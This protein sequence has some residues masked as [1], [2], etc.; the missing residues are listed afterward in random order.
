MKEKFCAIKNALSKKNKSRYGILLSVV[1]LIEVLMILLVSTYSWVETISSIEITNS[2]GQVDDYTFTNALVGTGEGFSGQPIDLAKYF[3]ASGN[4]HLA[5]ASSS[6]G[7]NFFFPQL[8]KTGSTKNNYRKGNINDKNTNYI[9]F[10]FKVQAV[11]TDANFYFEQVPTFKIGDTVVNDN[12]IRIALTVADA[13]GSNPVTKV[14]SNT[15][16]REQVVASISGDPLIQSSQIYAF[17]DYDN[18]DDEE[19]NILFSVRKGEENA[20]LVTLT[21]WLQDPSKSTAY[22]GKTLT[23]NNFRIVTAVK[24]TTINFVDRTSAFN[25]D[26]AKSS[27]W[28]WVGNDEAIMWI[29]TSQGAFKMQKVETSD[30]G[31]APTWTITLPTDNL[32][33]SNDDF[34]FYR[35]A[36]TVTSNPQENHYNFWKTKLSETSAAEIPTYK[37]YGNLKPGSDKEGY[38]TWGSVCEIMVTRDEEASLVL[39]TPSDPKTAT[40]ITVKT[41]NNA[42]VVPMNYNNGCWRV[43]IPNDNNSADLTISFLGNTINAI[44]RDKSESGSKFHVTSKSTGYWE[45]ASVVEVKVA[46]SCCDDKGNPIMGKVSVTGGPVGETR[47]KVTKGTPVDIIA[48]PNLIP[49]TNDYAFEGWYYDDECTKPLSSNSTESFTPV[50]K[51]KTYT[52][53]ARFQYNVRLTAITDDVKEDNAGGSV[54]INNGTAGAKASLYVKKGGS[55]TLKAVQT[56]EQAEDYT[57]MGWIDSENHVVYPADKT[58]IEITNLQEPI[59]YFAVY[60]IKTYTL[61][62]YALNGGNAQFWLDNTLKESGAHITVTVTNKQSVVYKAVPDESSGY[63]FVGWY[64][65]EACSKLKT[66]DPVFTANKNTD[67]KTY[68]AKFQLK[69]YNRTV[70]A[71]TNGTVDSAKGGTVKVI[72]D[73]A[74]SA[75]G[76]KATEKITHG[77]TAT[78]VA[79]ANDGYS[80]VGWYDAASG[81]TRISTSSTYTEKNAI[82]GDKT[83][84]A[85]FKQEFSVSLTARTDGIASST[86]GNVQAG[87]NPVGA[88]S[89]ATVLYGENITIKALVSSAKY[90]FIG[91]YDSSNT[92]QGN[93]ATKNLSNVTGNITLFADFKVK[94]FTIKAIAVSEGTEGSAGGTVEFTSPVASS[95]AT[96]TVTVNYDGSATFKATVNENDGYEFKGWF[97][98]AAMTGTPYKTDLEFELTNIVD[99]TVKT[100]YAKFDLKQYTVSAYAITTGTATSGGGTVCQVVND[101]EGTADTILN[102][103]NVKHGSQITL[104][105]KPVSGA[106]FLG[107][108]D[109]ETDGNQLAD[110]S[111]TDLVLNVEDNT[112][113][114]ARFRVSG[115]TIYF[116]PND[117][118]KATNARFAA[119]MWD[120]SVP[121]K[122]YDLTDEDGDGTYCFTSINSSTKII[123]ARMNP[124]TTSNVWDN[125]WSQTGNLDVPSGDNPCYTITGG[126]DGGN[127]STG[128][129]G[130]YKPI[131]YVS[132]NLGA[133]SIDVNGITQSDGDEFTGGSITVGSNTY[134]SA[135]VLKLDKDSSFTATAKG[136]GNYQFKGW[137]DNAACTGDPLSTGKLSVT[138]SEN[139]TYYAKFVEQSNV[140]ITFD[141]SSISSWVANDSAAIYAYDT[142]AK[143]AYIMTKD[144]SSAKY[145]C[146]VPQTVTNI[147]FYRC[148]SKYDL[149]VNTSVGGNDPG[150]AGYWNKWDAG[151]RG[152]N[153]TYST[154]SSSWS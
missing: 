122:W 146:S 59:N 6:D 23:C 89:S 91:W 117:G 49:N 33:S 41:N 51:S 11:G 126:P 104:R 149:D 42:S 24:N 57:F 61:E 74:T 106:T 65:D 22:D 28:N 129:W 14:Y 17:G 130:T 72:T 53:Y 80:F 34:Y 37:A 102:V 132:V 151:N 30:P 70:H 2:A 95:G 113:V 62:A 121:A 19:A 114:Y 44:K 119:Y 112:Q 125:K 144:S 71:V 13:D 133:V 3:R 76:A 93:E 67:P 68:Y 50:E 10:S 110:A 116:K 97:N 123:F 127:N 64:E 152:S 38:G 40:H 78:L 9:S 32:G 120:D 29:K 137:Y 36:K 16:A 150:K 31:A 147:T 45:P 105:A 12:K 26:N 143:T 21:A 100:Y 82:A 90:S 15:E 4:V 58:T 92:G 66:E 81:G 124:A 134:T 139:K 7:L 88:T 77:N 101:T 85:I 153:K 145:T 56:P 94:T 83:Y 141:A 99:S 63:E 54:Q 87:S 27:T 115:K 60:K 43:F 103:N 25:S 108:Y 118:W 138:L 20:K 35:T 111:T 46:S 140:T 154:S 128:T 73:L 135:T 39:P 69:K 18:K 75:A 5:S 84:Y 8:A 136:K 55:V 48:T 131:E 52:L 96:A 86:G 79:K 109:A 107:W 1:A 98:N 142:T 148:S 47:V